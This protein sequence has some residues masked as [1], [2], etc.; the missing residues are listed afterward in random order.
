[1]QGRVEGRN[2]DD[3]LEPCAKTTDGIVK[4]VR[5][6]FLYQARGLEST[7]SFRFRMLIS[8]CSSLCCKPNYQKCHYLTTLLFRYHRLRIFI[9]F[10][11]ERIP[12]G[13]WVFHKGPVIFSFDSVKTVKSKLA[14]VKWN[15]SFLDAKE[16]PHKLLNQHPI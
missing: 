10:L 2:F 9:V 1:M 8:M 4:M 5:V 6:R 13:P 3:W 7:L 14:A 16:K 15:F 11:K 12:E